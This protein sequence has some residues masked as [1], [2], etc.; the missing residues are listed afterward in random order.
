MKTVLKKR[1]PKD[2]L[3]CGD[4]L[5]DPRDGGFTGEFDYVFCGATV[6]HKPKFVDPLEYLESM[7]AVMFRMAKKGLAFDVFSNRVDF[8]D[9]ITLYVDPAHLLDYCYSLSSRLTFKNDFRPY[10]I[11]VYLYKQADQDDLHI[12]KDWTSSEPKIV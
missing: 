9:P 2:T 6:Q 12:F 5:A 3:I 7:I 4:I 11:M 10:E 1:L 8:E